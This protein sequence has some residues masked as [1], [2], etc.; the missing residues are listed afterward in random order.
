MLVSVLKKQ[1]FDVCQ[2]LVSQ[3]EV[4][5]FDFSKNPLQLS[6]SVSLPVF[7]GLATQRQ[8]EQAQA[9]AQDALEDRRAEE[10][11]LRTAVTQAYDNLTTAYQLIGLQDTNRQVAEE[12]L[13]M[14]RQRYAVGAANILEL[15]DAQTSVQT[16]ERDYL[17]ALYDFQ[18]DLATLEAASGQRLRPG[19]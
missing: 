19:G 7:N 11:T 8:L 3:S 5:P 10:L 13:S 2:Q 6:L 12:R 4:F 9:S 14:A 16:A 18:I 17:N 1:K 15:L